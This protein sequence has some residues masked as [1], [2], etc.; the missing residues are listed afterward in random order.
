MLEIGDM[1][2]ITTDNW[3]YAPD[4][5]Q[6]KSVFGTIKGVHNSEETLGIKTN[7]RSTNWYVTIGNMTIAGCQIHYLLKTDSVSLDAP[8]SEIEHQG[9]ISIGE[10]ARSRI[11]I[12]D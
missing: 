1:A 4:G 3:F 11:Y 12:A 9:Q 5:N 10:Y 8:T 2:L 7:A 6:Y